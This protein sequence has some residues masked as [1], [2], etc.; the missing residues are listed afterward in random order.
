MP[1]PLGE[2]RQLV[3][4]TRPPPIATLIEFKRTIAVVMHWLP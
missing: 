3:G 1:M 2:R 4:G